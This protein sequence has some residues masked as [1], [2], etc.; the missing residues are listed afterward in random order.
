[1]KII[2]T[3][4]QY[5]DPHAGASGATLKL[6]QEYKKL[7]HQ[8]SYYSFDN[9]PKSLP[10]ILKFLTF[11][12]W[13]ARFLWLENKKQSIDVVDAS[14]RDIWIWGKWLSKL[15][16]NSPLLVTRS[17][18][19]EHISHLQNKEDVLRGDLRFSW[20]YNLYR[21]SIYLWE[22]TQ[23]LRHADLI[24]LLNS[25]E[26][27]YAVQVLGI[28]PNQVRTVANGIPDYLLNLPFTPISDRDTTIRIAQVSTF[29]PRKGVKFS[30]PALNTI[31]SRYPNVEM[32]FLGTACRECTSIEQVY[33]NFHP[34]LRDRITVIPR[35][36]HQKLPE[37]LKNYHIKLFPSL[38]EGFGMALIE[39]MACGLA[40]ITTATGGP[41]DIICDRHDG[42]II[43]LRDRKAIETA[44][45]E[46]IGDRQKLNKLRQNA[47]NKAQKYS[48]QSIA[49]SSISW[50]EAA[51]KRK[52]LQ[53]Q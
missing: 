20:K 4:H 39:A 3:I 23:S 47:Y 43:P 40:P 35:F 6:G 15:Q 48:W 30:V 29:I 34:D 50:Y 5:L 10:D 32:S 19:L 44:L 9:L 8:V 13:V 46:L 17:H 14:T 1:M 49:K 25:E 28:K 51:I 18:G 38:S 7:G 41:G 2:F 27:K 53:N 37:L 12:L 22:A 21:G 26:H 42:L 33:A 45:E 31:L 52:S 11:P 36:E 24:F 16:R